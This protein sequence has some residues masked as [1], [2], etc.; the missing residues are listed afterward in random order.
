METV[1]GEERSL[2]HVLRVDGAMSRLHGYL[3]PEHLEVPV[4]NALFKIVDKIW[5]L[6]KVVPT[7]REL[8]ALLTRALEK[9]T[10]DVHNLVQMHL[11]RIYEIETTEVT[12][13]EI[14]EHV[15]KAGL[16]SLSGDI[17]K[18]PILEVLEGL[19][20]KLDTYQPLMH[21]G[22]SQNVVMPLDESYM[23]VVDKMEATVDRRVV[24]LGFP[25]IDK[26]VRGGGFL[27]GEM[28]NFMALTNGGK[29]GLMVGGLVPNF[30]KQGCNVIYFSL[31]VPKEEIQTR[32]Y[33]S[34][35][36]ESMDPPENSQDWT[37]EQWAWHNEKTNKIRRRLVHEWMERHRVKPS[38]IHVEELAGG[39]YNVA[40]LR[41][42]KRTIE[43]RTGH[44]DIVM[45]DYLTKVR[46]TAK[47]EKKYDAV[48]D[49]AEDI[50]GWGIEEDF[51]P[52][53]PTQA[54][55]KGYNEGLITLETMAEGFNMSWPFQFSMSINQ[56]R[57]ERRMGDKT[58]MQLALIK[59]TKGR[60]GVVFPMLAEWR[61]MRFE[62]N[63]EAEPFDMQVLKKVKSDDAQ[64]DRR[65]KHGREA[66]GRLAK[67][68]KAPYSRRT[69]DDTG[70]LEAEA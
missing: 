66:D 62:E 41:A 33:A 58:P 8:S 51:I 65:P 35:S 25:R 29:T 31:D 40:A 24:R 30:L 70:E 59:N 37:R 9:H 54:N 26:L 5:D 32:L 3:K 39:K 44:T 13:D 43:Q 56:T 12:Y 53:A 60:S 50:H 68:D 17:A 64:E 55:R 10:P 38:Q 61:C 16:M 45:I 48:G 23:E 42:K 15:T 6:K 21:G 34:L 4:Y 19:K 18:K 27:P 36:G 2:A 52:I 57:D 20:T 69:T 67:V 63:Y 47:Y 11:G 28:I 14:A 7:R 49:V 46:S 22:G 1:E